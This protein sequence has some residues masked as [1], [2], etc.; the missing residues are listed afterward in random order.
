MGRLVFI[1]RLVHTG[2]DC[3]IVV[4][5]LQIFK[6][7]VAAVDTDAYSLG[8]GTDAGLFQSGKV[9]KDPFC[10]PVIIKCAGELSCKGFIIHVLQFDPRGEF[11]DHIVEQIASVAEFGDLP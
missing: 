11:M 3:L 6:V 2:V 10:L 4:A 5:E 1:V 9:D 8:G 7:D